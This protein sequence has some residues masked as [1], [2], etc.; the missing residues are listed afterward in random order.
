MKRLILSLL[1][2][3]LS[4]AAGFAAPRPAAVAPTDECIII[5]GGPTLLLWEKWKN[6]PHDR[7]WRNFTNAAVI[8]IRELQSQG[9]APGQITWMVYRTA[10]ETRAKQEGQNLLAEINGLAQSLGC[11]LIYFRNAGEIIRYVNQGRPRGT[12][13]VADFEYFGH[14]N[15]ACWMFDYSNTI[16]SASKVWL[17]EDELAQIDR[18]AFARRAYVKSWGC[19]TAESMSG[20]FRRTTGVRMWGA[21]GRTQY[22]THELPVLS[23]SDAGKWKY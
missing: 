14:S 23:D 16:D 8:R 9:V 5:S 15:K 3:A 7:W 22:M 13:K 6:P 19:H 21:V 18:S 11:K 10:Y 20:K 4:A 2:L 1:A 12:V 17:H